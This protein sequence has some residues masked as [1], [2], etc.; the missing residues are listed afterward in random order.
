MSATAVTICPS[1]DIDE[2]WRAWLEDDSTSKSDYIPSL[3][4]LEDAMG[5]GSEWVSTGPMCGTS[6]N[7][8]CTVNPS[9]GEC[10]SS[11]CQSR[12]NC[13]GRTTVWSRC[14]CVY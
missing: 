9:A 8:C 10:A 14:A 13:V 1:Q 11:R 2:M 4:D 6:S 3:K 7:L 12:A 5:C